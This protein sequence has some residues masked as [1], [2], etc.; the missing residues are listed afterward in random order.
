MLYFPQTLE[1][2]EN[3]TMKWRMFT[4]W[5]R[6]RHGLF[7][8]SMLVIVTSVTVGALLWPRNNTPITPASTSCVIHQTPVQRVILPGHLVPA[9]HDRSPLR[10]TQC[11]IRL[12]LSISFI[13]RNQDEFNRLLA[14]QNDPNS[15]NYHKY[16][17]PTDIA[18]RFGQPQDRIDAFETFLQIQRITVDGVDPDHLHLH[19]HGTVAAIEQAFCVTLADY[20]FNKRIVFAP[21]SEPSVPDNFDNM[22]LAIVGLNNV[23]RAHP[24]RA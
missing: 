21:T 23:G 14:E 13:I 15:P 6:T 18:N 2:Q 9:L 5:I 7:L 12:Q 17:T 4:Q 3:I 24:E 22:I 8:L 16:L 20:Q 1:E 10:P 19:A 11:D